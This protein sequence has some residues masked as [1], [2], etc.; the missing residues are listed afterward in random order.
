MIII[1]LHTHNKNFKIYMYVVL[2]PT[3]A[4]LP[5]NIT[6]ITLFSN[7]PLLWWRHFRH[8]FQYFPRYTVGVALLIG[9]EKIIHN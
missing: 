8:H 9:T 5:S 1:H 4:T 7:V 6:L 2:L 3:W